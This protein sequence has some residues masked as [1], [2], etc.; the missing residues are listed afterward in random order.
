MQNPSHQFSLFVLQIDP[1][2][3]DK[4]PV[5]A[6]CDIR[7]LG[8]FYVVFSFPDK[9]NPPVF[10]KCDWHCVSHIEA[11]WDLA[12]SIASVCSA[13]VLIPSHRSEILSYFLIH[14]HPEMLKQPLCL[15][16][17]LCSFAL[18]KII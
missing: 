14:E 16:I 10:D 4:H 2:M 8:L 9:S 6:M 3:S 13:M 5:K 18:L 17:C 7:D 12:Y 15:M 1:M 11:A